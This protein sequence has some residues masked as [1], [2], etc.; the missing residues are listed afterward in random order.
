MKINLEGKI[1]K[2]RP[3][4]LSDTKDLYENIKDGEV[5][6]WTVIPN[7]YSIKEAV[8]FIRK[9]LYKIQKKKSFSFGIVLKET[10]KVIGGVSLHEVDWKN[11]RAELSYW[12]GKKYW[13]RGIATEAV[14]LALKLGFKKLKLHRIY[15]EVAEKNIASQKVLDKCGFRREG[16]ERE[17]VFKFGK[18]HNTY[19]YGILNRDC[20]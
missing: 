2:I 20:K 13:G 3:L 14:L 19:W 7:P 18:W 8:R 12:L 6:R 9:S 17:E 5:S 11:E 10:N 1:V 4:K 16:M 15:A